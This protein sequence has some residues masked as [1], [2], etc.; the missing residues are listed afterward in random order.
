MKTVKTN[1]FKH[2]DGTYGSYAFREGKVPVLLIP[3]FGCNHTSFTPLSEYFSDDYKLIIP[4]NR[5]MGEFKNIESSYSINDL[6]TDCFDLM[7][8]LGHDKFHVVGTSMGGFVAQVMATQFPESLMS[9]SLLCTTSNDDEFKRVKIYTEI[10]LTA[11][12]SVPAELGVSLSTDTIVSPNLK[13]NNLESYERILSLRLENRAE[14]NQLL[15]QREAVE[16]F[17][18]NQEEKLDLTKLTLPTLVMTGSGDRFVSSENINIFKSKIK[19]AKLIDV[20]DTDH[21]FF[22]EKPDVT[23]AGLC[24]FLE[25]L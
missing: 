13:E 16:F 14:L 24:S 8:S 18:L 25:K 3:G 15:W 12:Y 22:M 19:H 1:S 10:E 7:K 21:L 20:A 6:A 4:D 17:F 11:F 5:G 23:A 9:L 2:R